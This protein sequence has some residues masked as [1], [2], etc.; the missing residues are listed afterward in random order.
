M[1]L[2]KDAV[3]KLTKTVIIGVIKIQYYGEKYD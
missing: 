3:N 2:Y 1:N